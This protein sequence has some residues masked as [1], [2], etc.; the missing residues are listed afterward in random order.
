MVVVL[1]VGSRFEVVEAYVGVDCCCLV[2]NRK[3]I[4]CVFCFFVCVVGI[5]CDMRLMCDVSICTV[6]LVSPGGPRLVSSKP[7]FA[8][9]TI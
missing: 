6:S 7:T 9:V 1:V 8:L 3:K 2:V 5:E 4:V